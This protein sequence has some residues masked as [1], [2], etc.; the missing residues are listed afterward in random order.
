MTSQEVLTLSLA[1][2]PFLLAGLGMTLLL[3]TG[4]L[5]IG[6]VIGGIGATIKLRANLALR[7]LVDIYTTIVRGVPE[8]IVVYYFYFGLNEALKQLAGFSGLPAAS[9]QVPVLVIAFVAL[10][11]IAGALAAELFRT[12]YKAVPQSE[13]LAARAF[14]MPP[15]L[16]FRRVLFPHIMRYSLPGLGNIWIGLLK[17]TSLISVMGVTELMRATT[18]GANST[19]APF[20]FY[21][22]CTALYLIVAL[23]SGGLFA[24]LE[25]RYSA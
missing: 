19:G 10:G 15:F 14:A 24:W 4:A 20:V 5:V 23:G 16:L 25:R 1:W 8:L 12:A 11:F 17:E 13:V 9:F 22:L 2:M 18:I 21:L 3:A 6:L 7:T